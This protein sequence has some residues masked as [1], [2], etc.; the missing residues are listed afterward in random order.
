M[1]FTCGYPLHEPENDCLGV[2]NEILVSLDV[3]DDEVFYAPEIH[4]FNLFPQLPISSHSIK[5]RFQFSELS[6]SYLEIKD[7][8]KNVRRVAFNS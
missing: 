8:M 4:H 3:L 6:K 1:W 5:V 7:V 2:V